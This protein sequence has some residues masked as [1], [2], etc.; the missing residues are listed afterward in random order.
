MKEDRF[1]LGDSPSPLPAIRGEG[2]GESATY[3]YEKENPKRQLTGIFLKSK[4]HEV[5]EQ[6]NKHSWRLS[7]VHTTVRSLVPGEA[8]DTLA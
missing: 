5:N 3:W 2:L 1:L 7:C 4:V 8:T 6:I